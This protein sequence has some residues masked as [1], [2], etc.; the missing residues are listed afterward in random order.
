M[1]S[2]QNYERI[3]LADYDLRGEGSTAQTYYSKDGQRL[4]KLFYNQLGA[5]SATR[6]FHIAQA[7]HHMGIDTPCPVRL[8]TDGE[9][10]G[11][12]FKMFALVGK[13]SFARI[14]SEEPD[15]VEPISREFAQRARKLHQTPA[16]TTILPSMKSL[17]KN[18]ID[19]C[20]QIPS[21]IL[22]QL[23]K[24]LDETPDQTTCLHGDLHM[25]NI[26][27]DGEQRM[28]IDV[29]DF[30]YGVP[31]WDNCILYYMGN[32]ISEERCQHLF[33]FSS[34]IMHHHWQYFVNEYYGLKTPQEF[35]DLEQ[36]MR[37]IAAAKLFYIETKNNNGAPVSEHLANTIRK[38]NN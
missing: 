13:R 36:S 17:V 22:D 27:T 18:W 25:G 16:D 26:I 11:T 14:V 30:A 4:A 5:D 31:E 37:R 35:H 10:I 29:G 34:D 28:W 19:R 3:N 15:L 24:T 20:Q 9:R 32:F 8:I 1:D 2:A 38:L 21:D 33:H 6:E 7:V 23:I 12:E